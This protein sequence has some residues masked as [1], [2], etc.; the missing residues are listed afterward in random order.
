MGE[1]QAVKVRD[2][3]ALNEVELRW[4]GSR[5]AFYFGFV[6]RLAPLTESGPED[7]PAPPSE[8]GPR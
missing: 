3:G 8:T 5:S 7:R 4:R 2:E 6:E 1:D